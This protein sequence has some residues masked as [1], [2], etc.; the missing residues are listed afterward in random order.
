M[1]AFSVVAT[2]LLLAGCSLHSALAARQSLTFRVR[3]EV[4]SSTTSSVTQMRRRRHWVTEATSAEEDM[5]RDSELRRSL[6]LAQVQAST[7][8]AAS[9]SELPRI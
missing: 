4:V 7:A 3:V 9:R 2:I 6:V 8:A 1:S 5:H